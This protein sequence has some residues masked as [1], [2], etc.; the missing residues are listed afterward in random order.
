[1]PAVT[2]SEDSENDKS[3]AII[4]ASDIEKSGSQVAV[5]C[6]IIETIGPWC[7]EHLE[8]GCIVN[9]APGTQ[10]QAAKTFE[11]ANIRL[12]DIIDDEA[13][14]RWG[15]RPTGA[16]EASAATLEAHRQK[17]I[18]QTKLISELSAPHKLMSARIR[19]FAGTGWVAWVGA[20]E[21]P[22][23]LELNGVGNSPAQA[24]A[25]FDRAYNTLAKLSTAPKVEPTAPKPRAGIM[26]SKRKK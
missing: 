25:A 14:G 12:R 24:F 4:R 19:F 8:T 1:M 3:L 26:R 11:L 21:F 2:T 16:E 20:G 18:A 22:H 9:C 10:E 13:S 5:L 23:P 17:T 7:R 15:L 6:Q